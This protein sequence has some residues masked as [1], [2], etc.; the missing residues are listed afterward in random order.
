MWQAALDPRGNASRRDRG[1]EA[2]ASNETEEL[3]VQEI[4]IDTVSALRKKFPWWRDRR[5]ELYGPISAM[6]E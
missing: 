3:L 5:P 6:S 1:R 4:D 2:Q